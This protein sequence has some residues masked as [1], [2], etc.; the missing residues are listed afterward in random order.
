MENMLRN[1]ENILHKVIVVECIASLKQ[2]V[3]SWYGSCYISYSI[4]KKG[5]SL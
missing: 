5:D 1:M 3:S 4:I 2:D